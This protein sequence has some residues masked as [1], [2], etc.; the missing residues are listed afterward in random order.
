MADVTTE[1]SLAEKLGRDVGARSG[2]GMSAK[3]EPVRRGNVRV[4][5]SGT[6]RME[7]EGHDL[8]MFSNIRRTEYRRLGFLCS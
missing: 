8:C 6:S 5:T 2:D 7:K 4:C 1:R 3:A